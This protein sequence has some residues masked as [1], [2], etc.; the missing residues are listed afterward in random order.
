M[1]GLLLATWCIAAPRVTDPARQT[2]LDRY[3]AGPDPAYG[4]ERVGTLTAPAG[5][6]HV[7]RMR[8]Q[9]WRNTN[10]VN[11]T[12]W[13]HW[14]LVAVPA[15][16]RH[17]T[18]LLFI[19]G[20]NNRAEPPSSMDANLIRLA[21][22][23]HS[24]VAELRN[25]PNQPLMFHGDGQERVEDD[26]IAYTWDRFLRTGDEQWP[27]R[28][29]M[30]KAAVRAMDTVTAFCGSA[31]GGGHSV[32]RFVVA[33]GS[34]RGWTTWTTAAVDDRVVAIVPIVIDV[35]NLEASMRHHYAAYGFWAPAVGDYVAHGIM[36]WMGSA[37]LT[38]L[39][40][41]EDPFHYRDRLTM[42]KLLIH[43]T[44]DQFFLPDSWQFYFDELPGEKHLR[45]VPNADH[46]LRGTDAFDTLKAFYASILENRPRPRFQWQYDPDGTLRVEVADRPRGVTLWQATN[47]K[48]RDFR[49]ETFGTNW[50]ARPLPIEQGQC[51]V[52]LSD[53]PAGWTA[54]LVELT[55]DGPLNVPL[56]LTT[57]VW[58]RPDR[59]E[60][61]F[62]P[63]KPQGTRSAR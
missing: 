62:V 4:F 24:V 42:P 3:V 26:L 44:G 12:V 23:T 20:G 58:V 21:V 14:L 43:A 52:R 63:L 29:P 22:E 35:L 30:T 17:R 25:V 46:S 57:P 9:T 59:T 47:P 36:N 55:Y 16:V 11:R 8:S 31:E 2:A 56:K 49:V 39:A 37:E 53:P 54:S 33:G 48:A 32:Q 7:L 18:A 13:E 50:V 10:E 6:V 5:Q 60:H 34:K 15:E 19:G 45:Y 61:E 40:R 38:A 1:P 27:A 28:L 41:I 51:V